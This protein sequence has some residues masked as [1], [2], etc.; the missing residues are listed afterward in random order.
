MTLL[1]DSLSK[2][3]GL[4]LQSGFPLS[5]ILASSTS[6]SLY[7]CF[8]LKN[9]CF[10]LLVFTDEYL[11]FFLEYFNF[12]LEVDDSR[13][14]GAYLVVLLVDNCSLFSLFGCELLLLSG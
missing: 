3:S 7:H 2:R 12:G 13:S 11:I 14:E 6:N 8:L 9:F 10:K 4:L 5:F 1:R